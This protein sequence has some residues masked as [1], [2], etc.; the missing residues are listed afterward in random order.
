MDGQL[1]VTVWFSVK[2]IAHRLA[3]IVHSILKTMANDLFILF[4]A[5]EICNYLNCKWF[6]MFDEFPSLF[7]HLQLLI[8]L[9]PFWIRI[10]KII[11]IMQ[12]PVH[13]PISFVSRSDLNLADSLNYTDYNSVFSFI[14]C[15]DNAKR[16]FDRITLW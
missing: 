1:R 2:I 15:V 5:T 16:F 13:H 11:I 8:P 3:A 12:H 14:L 4:H 10:A 7:Y 6:V 9:L